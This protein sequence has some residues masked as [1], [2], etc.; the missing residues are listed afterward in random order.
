MTQFHLSEDGI[1]RECKAQTVESCTATPAD[2]KE[3][4]DTKE[5]AQKAYETK[6]NQ[7]KW[8][9]S[10]SKP[11]KQKT[12]TRESLLEENKAHIDRFKILE[13]ERKELIKDKLPV[14]EI[15][16]KQSKTA[17]KILDNAWD[18]KEL[19]GSP[20]DQRN[21]KLN[22]KNTLKTV[23]R[24]MDTL[25]KEI[26]ALNQFYYSQGQRFHRSQKEI[27]LKL[28]RRHRAAKNF[29]LDLENEI[30]REK[31]KLHLVKY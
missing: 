20:K 25:L 24:E 22:R 23:K 14:S 31:G 3:H 19:T 1:A 5:Q 26:Q 17:M 15:M 29:S 8:L 13:L 7:D 4:Y 9:G 12:F 6:Q 28:Q 27:W 30:N 2:Q 18:I 21:Y 11:S 10:L 16:E